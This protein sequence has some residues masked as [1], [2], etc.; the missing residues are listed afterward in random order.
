VE[1][2]YFSEQE[3]ADLVVRAAKLQEKSGGEKYTPGISYDELQKMAAEAGID[4][5]YLGQALAGVP[6][7]DETAK[8]FLGIPLSTEFER[9]V[10]F[11]LPPE[12]FDVVADFFPP[13]VMGHGP[14]GPRMVN[15]GQQVGRTLMMQ[16]SQW[17]T[18]GQLRMT[19]RNGRTRITTKATAFLAYFVGLHVP[20]I[21][22][23]ILLMM[24]M[25]G[26][27]RPTSLNPAVVLP[28]VMA[29]MSAGI[30]LFTWMSRAG[31]RKMREI[32]DAIAERVAQEG[33]SLR[34]NLSNS[35]VVETKPDS[36]E[37]RLSD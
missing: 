20:V 15:V 6:T 7:G 16:I 33:A 34:E 9:V 25:P 24:L 37:E 3:A 18:F 36:V 13:K 22:S 29:L 11:E 8:S 30:G 32:T 31:Q 10:D 4:P 1:K 17:P 26:Q 14:Q 21:I 19:S 27:T 12:S 28:T 23:F 35:S 5:E 2:R